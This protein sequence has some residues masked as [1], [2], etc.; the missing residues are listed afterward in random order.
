M[1]V[2]GTGPVQLFISCADAH[3][4]EW[5]GGRAVRRSSSE[6]LHAIVVSLF[7]SSQL[8]SCP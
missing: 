8:A 2:I 1:I 3:A 4:C 5:G 6:P 7:A